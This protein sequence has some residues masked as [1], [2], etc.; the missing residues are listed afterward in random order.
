MSILPFRARG[1]FRIVGFITRS[2][3]RRAEDRVVVPDGFTSMSHSKRLERF[4]WPA[5]AILEDILG[6]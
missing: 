4:L 2:I 6:A 1:S 3:V 5:T